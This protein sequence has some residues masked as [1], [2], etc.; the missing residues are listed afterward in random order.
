M[1][2]EIISL[3]LCLVFGALFSQKKGDQSADRKEEPCKYPKEEMRGKTQKEQLAIM[4]PYID[5]K[6]NLRES[7]NSQTHDKDADTEKQRKERE[8]QEANR[9]RQERQ[10][11]ER[12]QNNNT[13]Q[14]TSRQRNDPQKEAE[15][16]AREE[17]QRKIREKAREE[18]RLKRERDNTNRN[19]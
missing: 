15:Q 2:K 16:K 12:E 10:R 18:R 8:R 5:C 11:V 9:E 19:L 4:K 14:P 13:R 17:R 6:K 1:K 7:E 3:A